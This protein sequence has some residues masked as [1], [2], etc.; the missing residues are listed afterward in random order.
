MDYPT[1]IH[2]ETLHLCMHCHVC[3]VLIVHPIVRPRLSATVRMPRTSPEI[4]ATSAMLASIANAET[5]N[6][7]RKLLPILI[8]LYTT[9]KLRRYIGNTI[10]NTVAGLDPR[11]QRDKALLNLIALFKHTTAACS[12][13]YFLLAQNLLRLYKKVDGVLKLSTPINIAALSTASTISSA[14]GVAQQYTRT[15]HEY[16]DSQ[17]NILQNAIERRAVRSI[18]KLTRIVAT[19]VQQQLHDPDMPA[20]ISRVIDTCIELVRSMSSKRSAAALTNGTVLAGLGAP[21]VRRD[22]A[23]L[24]QIS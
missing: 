3:V 5:H 11:V 12:T 17:Q 15:L 6:S 4:T 19:Y 14:R 22:R 9:W 8:A 20:A 16:F 23:T 1:G 13:C 2:T 7:G 21:S 18:K 10:A 24:V